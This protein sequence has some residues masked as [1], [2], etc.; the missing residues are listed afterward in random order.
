VGA[1]LCSTHGTSLTYMVSPD[2]SVQSAGEFTQS[3]VEVPLL[4]D[5]EKLFSV[6][7]SPQFRA[8]HGIPPGSWDCSDEFPPWIEQL[9]LVCCKCYDAALRIAATAPSRNDGSSSSP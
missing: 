3:C 1:I 2:Y 8:A 5:G 4:M 7:L 6:C 9:K